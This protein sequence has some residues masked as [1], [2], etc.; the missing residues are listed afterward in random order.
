MNKLKTF[1]Q[2]CD[3]LSQEFLQL[4]INREYSKLDETWNVFTLEIK[5]RN[6][7]VIQSIIYFQCSIFNPIS[8]ERDKPS[9][10]KTNK[11]N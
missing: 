2:L 10:Q 6:Q 9:L 8:T 1:V 3:I 5:K 4:V 11:L 7:A